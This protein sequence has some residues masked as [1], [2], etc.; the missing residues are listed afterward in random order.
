MK[1]A[2]TLFLLLVLS[3]VIGTLIPQGADPTLYQQHFGEGTIRCF[4]FLGF[5]DLFHSWWFISILSFLSINLLICSFQRLPSLW[6]VVS[7]PPVRLDTD[8]EK[9]I[10]FRESLFFSGEDPWPRAERVF[11][12]EGYH[13]R[14]EGEAIPLCAVAYKGQ[15]S[16][17]GPY[18]VHLSI[19][20]VLLGATIDAL[21]GFRGYVN[22]PEKGVVDSFQ[23]QNGKDWRKLGFSLRCDDFEASYY[24][25]GHRPKNYKS[26]LTVIE[27]GQ[28]VMRK[29]LM[30]N[31]PLVYKGIH[32]YQ[33][34][35]GNMGEVKSV[36]LSLENPSRKESFQLT[37]LVG[38]PTRLEGTDYQLQILR[39]LP[40]FALDERFLAFSRSE[41]FN[42]PAVEVEIRKGGR[43]WLR[44]WVFE[45][46]KEFHG[47][48][49]K[50]EVRL[51][52]I[53][54][55]VPQFTGLQVT[56]DPGLGWVWTGFAL[57]VF[58][59]GVS[60]LMAERK[61]WIEKVG[62]EGNWEMRL[63]GQSR[64]GEEAFAQE[65]SSICTKLQGRGS[66]SE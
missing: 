11:R 48:K 28:E 17:I 29:T 43:P 57:M 44:T 37:A 41:E 64:R 10:P 59:L 4:E 34:S 54:Y 50:S 21:F 49:G 14:R 39:F 18:L 51:G 5:L 32:I 22:L 63:W 36:T 42:N 62:C 8:R 19:L 60:L 25:G 56:R 7:F 66:I 9:A 13:L 27:N 2:L 1:L 23:L 52:L 33:S 47:P 12:D 6:Q 30:V 58:G 15:W 31:R 40:D 55:D 3:S 38:E 16:R 35:F 53:H 46:F 26:Q 61:I 65:F 20:I 45:K 24:E